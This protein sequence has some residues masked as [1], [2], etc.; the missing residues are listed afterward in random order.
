MI[1]TSKTEH[2]TEAEPGSRHISLPFLSRKAVVTAIMVVAGAAS[3]RSG[4][5][6]LFIQFQ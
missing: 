3:Q 1:G 5:S 2:K 4:T 6:S